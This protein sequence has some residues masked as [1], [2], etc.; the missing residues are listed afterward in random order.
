LPT[1]I[2]QSGQTTI[3]TAIG[4]EHQVK[5]IINFPYFAYLYKIMITIKPLSAVFKLV[6]ISLEILQ[7]IFLNG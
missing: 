1:T 6:L 7:A 5:K 2:H 4:I 3:L